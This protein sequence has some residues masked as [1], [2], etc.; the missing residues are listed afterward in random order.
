MENQRKVVSTGGVMKWG[1]GAGGT[2]GWVQGTGRGAG[3]WCAELAELGVRI[4]RTEMLQ[5]E[6]RGWDRGGERKTLGEVRWVAHATKQRMV[7]EGG[8][9]M[10]SGT[11]GAPRVCCA[12]AWGR[13]REH[14][15]PPPLAHCR[16]LV[17]RMC[18]WR[19]RGWGRGGRAC[20]GWQGKAPAA[21][22]ARSREG[23]ETERKLHDGKG[24]YEGGQ[25]AQRCRGGPDARQGK[26]WQGSLGQRLGVPGPP[27]WL[28]QSQLR[29]RRRHRR[30]PTREPGQGQ[31]R[32]RP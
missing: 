30:L 1:A 14:G 32:R 10:G 4:K 28:Q 9:A 17:H 19:G 26:Q 11:R 15:R 22:G 23:E 8:Q 7:V 5:M 12:R 2:R 21:G 24:V 6:D 20:A 27:R 31:P 3:D 18:R 16:R 29:G 25:P 13:S